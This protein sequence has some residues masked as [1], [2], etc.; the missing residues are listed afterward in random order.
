MLNKFELPKHIGLVVIQ[1]V[2][3]YIFL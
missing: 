1:E 2:Y 3:K